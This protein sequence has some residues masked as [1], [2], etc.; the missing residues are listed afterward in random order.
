MPSTNNDPLL[1]LTRRFE[2]GQLDL[3][4]YRDALRTLYAASSDAGLK[5]TVAVRY[6][7]LGRV[8]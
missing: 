2:L 1:T 5:K 6:V 7:R 4:K 3:T 8:V